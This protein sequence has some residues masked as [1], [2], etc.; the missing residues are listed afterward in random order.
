MFDHCTCIMSSFVWDESASTEER[1]EAKEDE[2]KIA[3]ENAISLY[4]EMPQ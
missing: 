4:N 3:K 1:E 2:K